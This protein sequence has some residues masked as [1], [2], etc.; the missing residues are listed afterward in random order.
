MTPKVRN[1]TAT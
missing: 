1:V